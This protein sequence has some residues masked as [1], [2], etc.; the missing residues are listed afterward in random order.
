MKTGSVAQKNTAAGEHAAETAASLGLT[1][2]VD[3]PTR[4]KNT[5]DLILTDINRQQIIATSRAALRK[6]DH[7]VLLCS[8]SMDLRRESRTSRTIYD[9]GRAG[10]TFFFFFV[11]LLLYSTRKAE[12][13]SIKD[14]YDQQWNMPLSFGWELHCTHCN[15]LIKFRIVPWNLLGMLT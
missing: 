10:R 4:G 12:I 8:I 7:D 2:C 13:L 11:L 14:S 15:H 5:L 9:Y 6:S 3:F 1:Q